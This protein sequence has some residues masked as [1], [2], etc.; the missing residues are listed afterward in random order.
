VARYPQLYTFL[1]SE[2]LMAVLLT[3]QLDFEE[4]LQKL[5]NNNDLHDKNWNTNKMYTQEHVLC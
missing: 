1:W 3:F 2:E 5:A 4:L